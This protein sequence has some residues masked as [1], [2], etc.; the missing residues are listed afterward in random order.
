MSLL[1]GQGRQRVV[2]MH[3]SVYLHED[4]PDA[5]EPH[6]AV[7][8]AFEAIR[9]RMTPDFS[10]EVRAG[11]N[12]LMIEKKAIAITRTPPR[13]VPR[14]HSAGASNPLRLV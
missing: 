13:A 8:A 11:S 4:T 10:R 9:E 3:I 1:N 5:L 7:L 14:A 6:D 12:P 2:E